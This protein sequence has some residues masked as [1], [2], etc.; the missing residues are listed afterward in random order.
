MKKIIL[1]GLILIFVFNT[2]A[3]VC[4]KIDSAQA[5]V[6][7]F[8][9]TGSKDKF[10]LFKGQTE[11]VKLKFVNENVK[12]CNE[13]PHPEIFSH[14]AEQIGDKPTGGSYVLRFAA[15]QY[16]LTFTRFTDK[17]EFVFKGPA[18]GENCSW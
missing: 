18:K 5:E 7:L 6:K 9:V 3:Q 12:V 14:F 15:N 17:K 10:V 1:S 4:L 8:D 16:E 2:N 11:K 13:C